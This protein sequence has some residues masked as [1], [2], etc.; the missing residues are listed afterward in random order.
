VSYFT[1]ASDAQ[2]VLTAFKNGDAEILGF[3]ANGDIVIR[4]DNVTGYWT[5]SV[6]APTGT[7]TNVF[8]I[9]GTSS[10]SVVPYNP[11]YKP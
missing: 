1:S 7:S 10:T 9:K 11:N 3:K 2:A 5:D 8:F 4:V 6:K